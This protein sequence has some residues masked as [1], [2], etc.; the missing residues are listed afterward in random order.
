MYDHRYFTHASHSGLALFHR[1]P[2]RL[3]GHRGFRLSAFGILLSGHEKRPRPWLHLPEFQELADKLYQSS[4]S[5]QNDVFDEEA[6][7][8]NEGDTGG[9]VNVDWDIARSWF[10]ERKVKE[11]ALDIDSMGTWT[12]WSDELDGVRTA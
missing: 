10:E 7:G 2:T 4:D 8:G 3:A 9:I 6:E 12:G 11:K 5:L 1:R